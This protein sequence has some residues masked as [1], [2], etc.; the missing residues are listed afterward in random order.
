[1]PRIRFFFV[2]RTLAYRLAN[3]NRNYYCNCSCCKSREFALGNGAITAGYDDDTVIGDPQVGVFEYLADIVVELGHSR[4]AR[5]ISR[6]ISA[7]SSA[8]ASRHEIAF[9][10]LVDILLRGA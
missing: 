3:E 5:S 10:T 9:C 4:A 8:F 6:V 1:V 2:D 7:L